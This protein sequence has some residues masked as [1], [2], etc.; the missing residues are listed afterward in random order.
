MEGIHATVEKIEQIKEIT[1]G[2]FGRAESTDETV[3][4]RADVDRADYC[5]IADIDMK[6]V[7]M[8]GSFYG[9][10]EYFEKGGQFVLKCETYLK[11]GEDDYLEERLSVEYFDCHDFL[12]LFKEESAE[13]ELTVKELFSK[14]ASEIIDYIENHNFTVWDNIKTHIFDEMD[15]DDAPGNIQRDIVDAWVENNCDDAFDKV[16]DYSSSSDLCD[17]A[18]KIIDRL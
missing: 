5:K 3:I 15:K 4:L 16:M 8:L 17:Y 18:H 6:T 12:E 1:D 2:R 14:S 7:N 9:I 13:K 11:N 10:L